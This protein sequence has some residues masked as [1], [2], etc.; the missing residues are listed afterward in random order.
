L[1]FA[2]AAG[3]W[4]AIARCGVS[5]CSGGGFGVSRHTVTSA[6]GFTVSA[7]ILAFRIAMVPWARRSVRFSE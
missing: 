1:L 7:L 5:G 4:A 6:V 2:V 3:M